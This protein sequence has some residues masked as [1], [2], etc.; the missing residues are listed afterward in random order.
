MA[1]SQVATVL[2]QAATVLR[3]IRAMNL[4]PSIDHIAAVLRVAV[5][6]ALR[7]ASA[8]LTLVIA[9]GVWGGAGT[10]AV[11]VTVMAALAMVVAMVVVVLLWEA[12]KKR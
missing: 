6:T 11:L 7:L 10:V 8:R 2:Q 4:C 1:A 9:T 5:R 3:A 12:T